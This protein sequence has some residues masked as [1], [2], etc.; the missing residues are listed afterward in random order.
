MTWRAWI[1][2]KRVSISECGTKVVEMVEVVEVVEVV[3]VVEVVHV[4]VSQRGLYFERART[5]GTK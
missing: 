1:A 2:N 3:K 4:N 5:E